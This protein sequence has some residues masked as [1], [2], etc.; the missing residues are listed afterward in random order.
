MLRTLSLSFLLCTEPFG[1]YFHKWKKNLALYIT[2]RLPRSWPTGKYRLTE[3]Y[4]L[5]M[6]AH[7]IKWYQSSHNHL[8]DHKTH[9]NTLSSPAVL[10]PERQAQLSQY[11]NFH[12]RSH[13]GF[14]CWGL[15]PR[16]RALDN[17]HDWAASLTWNLQVPHWQ[18]TLSI[19]FLETG[20]LFCSFSGD[21]DATWKEQAGQLAAHTR[22]PLVLQSGGGSVLCG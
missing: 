1:L 9:Q 5:Q 7:F 8:C 10:S 22:V 21:N 3:L 6:F 11:L 19:A 14:W 20:G 16:P 4:I 15:N 17:H 13:L 2:L 12:L 18:Q